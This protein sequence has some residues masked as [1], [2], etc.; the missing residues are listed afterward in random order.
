MSFALPD[1][2]P[3][4]SLS[5]LYCA[6]ILSLSALY[7]SR[8]IVLLSAAPAAPAKAMPAAASRLIISFDMIRSPWSVTSAKVAGG[9]V[10]VVAVAFGER[11][12]LL[13]GFV[14]RDPVRFLDLAGQLLPVPF[15]AIP[16][17]VSSFS[18]G[19]TWPSHM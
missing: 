11:V 4:R 14:L 3:Q 10:V 17:H 9:V 18:H 19:P 16:V 15:D 1:I 5:T 7:A 6:S 13:L 8:D 2:E 12:D